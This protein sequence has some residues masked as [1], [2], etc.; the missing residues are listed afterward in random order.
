MALAR[1]ETLKGK[2]P[3]ISGM[4]VAYDSSAAPGRRVTSVQV[5]GN[6]LDDDRVY[7]LATTDYLAS[8]GD[9]YVSF[10]QATFRNTNSRANPL[11][12]DVLINHIRRLQAI[13]PR[14]ENRL[15]DHAVGAQDE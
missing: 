2:F 12:S 14:V 13:S 7:L 6:P 10:K 4:R 11:I 9:D 5:G 15:T 1:W 8:G 3:H